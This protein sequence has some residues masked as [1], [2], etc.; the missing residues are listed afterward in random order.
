MVYSL[1]KTAFEQGS[2][3]T[4]QILVFYGLIYENYLIGSNVLIFFCQ[5]NGRNL[6]FFLPNFRPTG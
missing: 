4:G 2:A 1:L 6:V 5:S 3:L